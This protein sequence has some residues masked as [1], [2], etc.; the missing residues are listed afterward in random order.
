MDVPKKDH[1]HWHIL[2]SKETFRDLNSSKEGLSSKEAQIRLQRDGENKIGGNSNFHWQKVLFDKINSI[3]IYILIGAS[4]IAL[5]SGEV[6]EFIVIFLIIVVTVITGFFQEYR[7]DKTVNALNKLSAKEVVVIRDGKKHQIPA[8]HLVVGD[9]VTIKR[10]DIIPADLRLIEVSGL[11]I[12]ESIITGESVNRIKTTHHLTQEHVS[13]GD[14]SNIA[15]SSTHVVAGTGTGIVVEI[16][17]NTQIGRIS[18]SIEQISSQKSP[19]QKKIDKMSERISYIILSVCSILFVILLVQGYPLY[20]ALLLVSALAIAGI[21]E[22]FPLVLSLALSN[23]I[24]KMSQENAIVKDITSVE[25]LGNTTVICT[26]KTGTLTQNLMR[27][28]EV[29]LPNSTKY[30]MR[31]NNYEPFNMFNTYNKNN[32]LIEIDKKDVLINE[33][34]AKGLILC[35]EAEIELINEKEWKLYGEPTEGALLTFAK[36]L[37]HDEYVLREDFKQVYV[38]PFDPKNK[39]MI[40][41]HKDIDHPTSLYYYMKGAGEIVSTKAEFVRIGNSVKKITPQIKKELEL[42]VQ[43]LNSKGLRVI[44]V[45]TKKV[46]NIHDHSNH[47]SKKSFESEM[48]HAF[49]FEGFLGIEDPIRPEV[50][51]A[52]EECHNAG[53]K[54][55]MITGDHKLIAQRIGEKLH[56]FNKEKNHKIVE[57]YELDNLSDDDLDAIIE[58][59]RIFARTSPEHKL[60]IIESFQRKGHI[61]AMTGD[62]VN[63]APALKKAD[64][65]VAMCQN[66]TEVAR[67][68]SNMVLA[69]DNFATIVKAVK[70]G[71]TIYNNIRRFI[72]YLLTGNFTEVTI[73]IIAILIGLPLPLTAL[74]ILFINLV[75]SSIPAMALSIE[76]TQ[77]KVMRQLPR[78][79]NERLFSSYL[80][81]K[82]G[83]L[84]PFILIGVLSLYAW[85]LYIVGSTVEKAMTVAFAS[86]IMFKLFHSF[87]ARR[88]HTTLFDRGFF[89][90]KSLFGAIIIT[91]ILLLM[92]IYT[93]LGQ[94]IFNTVPLALMDWMLISVIALSIIVFSELI[95]LSIQAEVKEQNS[96]QGTNLKVE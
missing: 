31:G 4:F 17:H 95:K 32:E 33:E 79:P 23:G 24:K 94:E 16:G 54:I 56:L 59:V 1:N 18:S 77:D 61:V 21:P 82:I 66:G 41:V 69:D 68:A 35:N 10:G 3:L 80:M 45:A 96:L 70:Q 19:I 9:I 89:D 11:E 44:G 63:D 85:E 7:A 43:E 55:V 46:S 5:I 92:T 53:I 71:R 28:V 84:I 83:V 49:V 6:I 38:K 8:Q 75:T 87:N 40:S 27:V 36:S 76:P 65:G 91:F 64:I 93:T 60:R 73:I 22:S 30:E 25:T 50:F 52:V 37:D 39:Y 67:E 62:G 72:F 78:S 20:A 81:T 51:G 86:I 48:E 29:A 2:T 58:D 15:F 14:M 90:N 34:F 12:N 88:L 13:L 47:I 42:Q 26:D 74:M 57:G